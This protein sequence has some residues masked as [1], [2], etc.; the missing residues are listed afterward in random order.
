MGISTKFVKGMRF[1]DEQTMDVVEMVLGGKV[2]N[3]LWPR[4]TVRWKSRGP[5]RKRRR[6][7][8]GSGETSAHA[9][10][11]VNK[12]P[13]II[14]SGHVGDVTKINPSIV[15]TPS[16]QG[17]IPVIAPGGGRER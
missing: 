13:E 5:E 11:D 3:P 16:D 8:S 6:P 14:D 9:S 7:D 10:A 2:N 17:F 15:T 4:S 12:L 1:T